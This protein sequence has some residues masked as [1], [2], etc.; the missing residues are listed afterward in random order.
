MTKWSEVRFGIININD[1]HTA[2]EKHL[3]G[4]DLKIWFVFLRVVHSLVSPVEV[5]NGAVVIPCADTEITTPNPWMVTGSGDFQ[6]FDGLSAFLVIS[7][8]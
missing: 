8:F 6:Y 3:V 4:Q 5:R 2:G 1:L 7:F